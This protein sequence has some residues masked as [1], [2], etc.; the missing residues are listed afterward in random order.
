MSHLSLQAGGSVVEARLTPWDERALGCTT[1][2]IVRLDAATTDQAAAMLDQAQAWARQQG[3][4]YLFGRIDANAHALRA[5][6]LGCGFQFVETS[7]TV[8]RSGMG[9]LPAVPRGCYLRCGRRLL[10]TFRCCGPSPPTTSGMVVFWKTLP[11]TLHTHVFA[12]PTG[13]RTW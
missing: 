7:L 10:R 11:S 6:V 12:P 1:A 3:V 2:E 5:A 13:L 8:S 9:Q 4:H